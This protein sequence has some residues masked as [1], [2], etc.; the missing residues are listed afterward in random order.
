MPFTIYLSLH[1]MQLLNDESV[2]S[3]EQEWET[4]LEHE[5]EAM[6]DARVIRAQ[7]EKEEQERLERMKK[8]MAEKKGELAVARNITNLP[9]ISTITHIRVIHDMAITISQN[10]VGHWQDIPSC[11]AY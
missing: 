7:K 5:K 2:Q 9:W 11:P 3:L 4:L 1:Q 6:K 8:E 10:R